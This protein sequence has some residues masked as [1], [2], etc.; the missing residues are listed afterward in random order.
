MKT[1]NSKSSRLQSMGKTKLILDEEEWKSPIRSYLD[2]LPSVGSCFN[3][4]R[5][6]YTKC[7]CLNSLV[8][9]DRGVEYLTKSGVMNKHCQDVFT[10][11]LSTTGS[12][13]HVDKICEWAVKYGFIFLV[14]RSSF[15][16]VISLGEQRLKGLLL[17]GYDPG[18]NSHDREHHTIKNGCMN[19]AT[20]QGIIDFICEE[21]LLRCECYAT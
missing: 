8:S 19:D 16:N 2:K 21:G 5:H 15:I 17:A 9:F 18:P 11:S 3:K 7:S 20:R 6:H 10:K 1:I 12:V 13:I 4:K 14:Y